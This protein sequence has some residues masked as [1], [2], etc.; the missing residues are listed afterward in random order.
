M[1]LSSNNKV[2]LLPDQL[3]V[4]AERHHSDN[5]RAV[6]T[7]AS[8]GGLERRCHAQLVPD[9]Q[10]AHDPNAVAVVVD[11]RRVGYVAK[12]HSSA[13][14]RAISGSNVVL[15]CVIYWNGETENGIYRVKLFP[16]L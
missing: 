16:D 14:R 12:V 9:P 5:I 4:T 15:K 7:G 6:L 11:G 1:R 8:N 10:N 2:R 13:V 3:V